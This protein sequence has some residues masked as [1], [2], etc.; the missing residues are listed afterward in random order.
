[1]ERDLTL[2]EEMIY[3]NCAAIYPHQSW[4]GTD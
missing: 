1:M 3:E 4:N 2:L